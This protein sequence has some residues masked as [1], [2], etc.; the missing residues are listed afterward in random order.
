MDRANSVRTRRMLRAF[1][2]VLLIGLVPVGVSSAIIARDSRR[3]ADAQ[4]R[5]KLENLVNVEQAALSEYFERARSIDRLL[6]R[7]PDFGGHYAGRPGALA[8][9]NAALRYLER[10]YPTSIGEACFIDRGGAEIARAVRGV[11][12]AKAELSPDESGNPFFRP[13]FVLRPGEVYQAPPYVSPD[14]GEWV[15]SNSTPITGRRAIVHFEITIE[16]FRR[17]A[18]AAADAAELVVVETRSGRVVFDSTTPQPASG[19]DGRRVPLG[20]PLDR[21]FV[22]VARAEPA[23]AAAVVD[24]RRAFYSRFVDRNPNNGNRWTIV[25]VNDKPLPSSLGAVV[26]W[27]LALVIGLLLLVAGAASRRW[28]TALDKGELLDRTE[29]SVRVLTDIAQ[30]LRAAALNGEQAAAE[31]SAAIAETTATIEELA[32]TAAT[33]A[34]HARSGAEAARQT[35]ETMS[36]MRAQVEAMAEQSSVLGTRSEEIG[37]ILGLIATM[38]DQTNMLALNATIEAARAGEAGRGFAVVATE[39]RRLAERSLASSSSIGAIVDAVREDTK[40]VVAATDEGRRRALNVAELMSSTASILEESI[41]VTQQQASAA[42]QASQ[43]IQQLRAGT[44]ALVT[45]QTRR[46]AIAER[47][48]LLVH[49]LRETVAGRAPVPTAQSTPAEVAAS[50]PA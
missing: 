47:L 19:S 27:P 41:L 43:T 40:S 49:D 33:I 17:Q 46:A 22:A 16:S 44:E 26:G 7:N 8:G 9:A 5:Q 45:E 31:Q 25:A 36:E 24:G 34:E 37:E 15:I 12:A 11:S 35:V 20:R 42:A 10:L 18:A 32:T 6:A 13:T 48:E 3:H 2:L 29:E 14:T 30:E 28:A 23:R 4:L 39:V 50:A 1:A 21:R 38:A